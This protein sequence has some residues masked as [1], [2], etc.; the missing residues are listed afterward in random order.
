MKNLTL[1][2]ILALSLTA[3]LSLSSYFF[4][5]NLIS[6]QEEYSYTINITGRQR[7]LSQRS[8][9]QLSIFVQKLDQY[10]LKQEELLPKEKADI[11][12]DLA[13]I[14]A[15][16]E[17]TLNL[18]EASH[19]KLV[20]ETEEKSE[21]SNLEIPKKAL[22][23]YYD[24][25]YYLDEKIRL[26][27]QDVRSILDTLEMTDYERSLYDQ[28]LFIAQGE[29]LKYLDKIVS[30]YEDEA[31]SRVGFLK[32]IEFMVFLSIVLLLILEGVFIFRPM[33]RSVKQR[34]YELRERNKELK[35][36]NRL[37]S[38][39]LAVMSH[40]IRTPM[41]GIMGMVSL[42]LETNIRGKP[43]YFAMTI[44]KSAYALLAILNDILDISKIEAN[45]LEMEEKP[46]DAVHA[47]Q[48]VVGLLIV[49]ATEKKI[50]L[51]YDIDPNGH[52]MMLGDITRFKQ[53]LFNLISNAVKF[54][55]EGHVK[56]RLSTINHEDP[57]I[58]T[59]KV[60]V[61]DTGIGI[62]PEDLV[63]IFEQFKQSYHSAN[64]NRTGT[65]LGLAICKKL[66]LMMNG[67]IT[68]QSAEGKGSTFE[69][70]VNLPKIY[71][72]EIVSFDH[73]SQAKNKVLK[74]L[75][76]LIADDDD[77]SRLVLSEQLFNESAVVT[78]VKQ[79]EDVLPTIVNAYEN[80]EPF[81]CVIID[82]Y[83][84]DFNARAIVTAIADDDRFKDLMLIAYGEKIDGD[85]KE[86][87][88]SFGFKEVLIKP[89]QKHYFIERL[90]HL[91]GRD[92]RIVYSKEDLLETSQQLEVNE[93]VVFS[94]V[95]ILLVEDNRTNQEVAKRMLEDLG[96][97]VTVAENGKRAI[98]VIENK[99]FDIVFT[100]IEM[101]VMNGYQMAQILRLKMED[102]QIP[103][104]PIIAL[105][106]SAMY[107]D[108]NK[109]R[110][111]GMDD[112]LMKPVSKKEYI[113]SLMKY[114]PDRKYRIE[115]NV[116]DGILM[117]VYHEDKTHIDFVVLNDLKELL[118][119]AF[120]RFLDNYLEGT[121]EYI[122][123]IKSAVIEED[124]EM[125]RTAAHPLKSSSQQI[126]AILIGDIAFEIEKAVS[127]DIYFPDID[128]P[129]RRLE[130]AY[131]KLKTIFE[132]HKNT[133]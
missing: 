3:L 43:R 1:K 98:E 55:D 52:Y 57:D 112:S 29:L 42:L 49:K 104:F 51:S 66:V 108:S 9:L 116:E 63:H 119:V 93:N 22:A 24:D 105:S 89:I 124:N 96:C 30:I 17:D 99:S 2:Y 60:T 126:G 92:N 6:V 100:D 70:T 133:D 127:E 86:T 65:G 59:T 129:V 39:F 121:R 109:E 7:M 101:P 14:K 110:S 123:V 68:V 44:K 27:I 113:K 62:L 91:I 73:M 77:V 54:T 50:D 56:V 33:V 28:T 106:G 114:V 107:A 130:A 11:L 102:H 84:G 41:S 5:T 21:V 45:C 38:E 69:F 16:I 19:I 20:Q 82:P 10:H 125:A 117:S 95:H 83:M 40:E 4:L 79:D 80:Q 18:F 81:D 132:E 74:G 15:S 47:V 94:G 115:E 34:V 58:V 128:E 118:G 12:H 90:K 120:E 78:Q 48:D 76:I 31:I 35:E 23:I 75:R 122:E 26:Y 72:N 67:D 25:P 111:A 37:K 13:A 46:F 131:K 32:K 53:V 64:H 85:K 87:L 88:L 97:E 8:A 61:E 71:N 36:A 103:K